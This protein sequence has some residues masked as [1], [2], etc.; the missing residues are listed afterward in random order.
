MKRWNTISRKSESSSGLTYQ[1]PDT[2]E[3]ARSVIQQEVEYQT[4]KGRIHEAVRSNI[5]RT[6]DIY[7]GKRFTRSGGR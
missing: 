6:A 3:R 5:S 2:L 7:E 1:E 4:A